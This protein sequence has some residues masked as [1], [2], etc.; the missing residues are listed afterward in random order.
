MPTNVVSDMFKGH[1]LTDD[2]ANMGDGTIK[3][4]CII[5]IIFTPVCLIGAIYFEWYNKQWESLVVVFATLI[6]CQITCTYMIRGVSIENKGILED[7]NNKIENYI[8]QL[9]SCTDAYTVVGNGGDL[10]N[11]TG[12][13][14]QNR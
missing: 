7:E 12:P 5:I 9:A 8:Q 4:I 3:K 13:I 2:M 11:S 1:Y 10:L 14:T 6:I